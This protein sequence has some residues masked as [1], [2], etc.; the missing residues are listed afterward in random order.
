MAI[1]DNTDRGNWTDNVND[2]ES[3]FDRRDI[4]IGPG[5]GSFRTMVVVHEIYPSDELE[6]LT[7]KG[8]FWDMAEAEAYAEDR[9]ARTHKEDDE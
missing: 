9:H 8:V 4:V 5:F 1:Y 2:W 6:K 7:H 3:R